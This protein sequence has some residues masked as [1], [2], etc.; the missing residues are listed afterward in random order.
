MRPGYRVVLPRAGGSGPF[1]T[2]GRAPLAG[3]DLR[4]HGAQCRQRAGLLPDPVAA[5]GRARHQS[6]NLRDSPGSVSLTEAFHHVGHRPEVVMR[7]A[8]T[9]STTSRSAW[10]FL[11][12]RADP[13]RKA[14]LFRACAA[15]A[16]DSSRAV[17]R[18]AILV[19]ECSLFI[20]KTPPELR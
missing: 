6:R 7:H 13:T 16:S 19:S 17:C 3:T 11:A 8:P 1:A 14:D 18:A 15:F 12:R 20:G 2:A 4:F 5:G 9:M 10:F